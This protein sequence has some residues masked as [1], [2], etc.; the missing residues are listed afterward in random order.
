MNT[1]V[2][3]IA[4]DPLKDKDTDSDENVN[5]SKMLEKSVITMLTLANLAVLIQQIN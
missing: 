3:E 5:I 4:S 2:K 1:N